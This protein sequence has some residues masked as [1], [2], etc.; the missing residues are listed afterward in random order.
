[1]L[2]NEVN[3]N[4]EIPYTLDPNFRFADEDLSKMPHTGFVLDDDEA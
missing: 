4:E 2:I 1:M 3:N